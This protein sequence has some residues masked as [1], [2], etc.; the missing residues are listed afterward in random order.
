M[1]DC[2]SCFLFFCGK[3]LQ[4][5]TFIYIRH[6]RVSYQQTKKELHYATRIEKFDVLID[7]FAKCFTSLC[8]FVRVFFKT[9]KNMKVRGSGGSPKKWI[10]KN[11]QRQRST[12]TI[13]DVTV[14]PGWSRFSKFLR[15]FLWFKD[16]TVGNPSLLGSYMSFV[17]QCISMYF[18][19]K[20]LWPFGRGTT[21]VRGLTN[22]GY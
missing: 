15:D 6:G 1:W 21:P 5:Q 14:S 3:E 13:L 7:F 4:V 22:H 8:F 12:I 2:G 11:W 10:P 18:I 9:K 20:S 16:W 17:F 19:F